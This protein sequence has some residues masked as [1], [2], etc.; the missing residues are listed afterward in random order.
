MMRRVSAPVVLLTLMLLLV[1]A[2]YI[3]YP[4]WATVWSS[5]SS[6]HGISMERYL[7]LLDPANAAA[8][9]AV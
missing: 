4:L 8:W 2:G 9:E 5:L 6:A 3:L 1:I 7:R